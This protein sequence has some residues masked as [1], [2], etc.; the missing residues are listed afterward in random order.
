MREAWDHVYQSDPQVCANSVTE[1]SAASA[2][3]AGVPVTDSG[4]Q[5][6]TGWRGQPEQP[7]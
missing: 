7:P 2:L 6:P 5:G 3:G 4:P 1:G